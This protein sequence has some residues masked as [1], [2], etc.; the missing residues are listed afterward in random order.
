MPVGSVVA[1]DY[2][3]GDGRVGF[4]FEGAAVQV[5]RPGSGEGRD[6]FV[7]GWCQRSE[8]KKPEGEVF[9]GGSLL[10]RAA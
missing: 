10:Q 9:H 2:L 7:L 3:S 8:R 6:G 4:S 1:D 5:E